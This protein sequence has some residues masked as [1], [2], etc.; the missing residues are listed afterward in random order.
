MR[1]LAAAPLEPPRR[2]AIATLGTTTLA[3]ATLATATLTA[4]NPTAVNPAATTAAAATATATAAAASLTAFTLAFPLA[5]TTSA[6]W[7]RE[8]CQADGASSG[9][10]HLG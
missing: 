5:A 10:T 1:Q 2:R 8:R 3:T 4:A 7:E 9:G 6:R